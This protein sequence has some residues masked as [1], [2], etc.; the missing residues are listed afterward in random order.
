MLRGARCLG[1]ILRVHRRHPLGFC[2]NVALQ[3]APAL[4]FDEHKER[5]EPHRSRGPT[6]DVRCKALRDV[7]V[8]PELVDDGLLCSGGLRYR[9]SP[10][11]A[12][13]CVLRRRGCT[14]DVGR[15]IDTILR[16]ADHSRSR[17]RPEATRR[18]LWYRSALRTASPAALGG[19]GCKLRGTQTYQKAPPPCTPALTRGQEGSAK[20]GGILCEKVPST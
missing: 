11:P 18:W 10:S 19:W 5:L 16:V 3:P 13:L 1:P 2:H 20:T 7:F 15:S 4:W 6:A 17:P 9:A 8:L 14:G 12:L